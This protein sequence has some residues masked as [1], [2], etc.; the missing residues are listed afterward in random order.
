MKTVHFLLPRNIYC[1][2][3]ISILPISL[4]E[5]RKKKQDP[6]ILG[7]SIAYFPFTGN[8]LDAS[9]NGNHGNILGAVLTS[10]RN[11]E[12]NS[13]YQFD[14]I[15]A[16][17]E[18][19]NRILL[20]PEYTIAAW[21]SPDEIYSDVPSSNVAR[22]VVSLGGPGADQVLTLGTTTQG[23]VWSFFSYTGSPVIFP[24]PTVYTNKGVGARRW[25]H[26][27]AVRKKNELQLYVDGVLES[28][29]TIPEQPPLY[30]SPYN[31]FIGMRSQ[32]FPFQQFKGKIDDVAFFKTALAEEDVAI[33]CRQMGALQ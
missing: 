4:T 18:I 33:L 19:P 8:A 28:R 26:L 11:G 15:T 25:A 24:V 5:C 29:M 6:D 20:N 7:T 22:T 21:A 13:A 10:G 23:S 14:G 16:R 9:K 3:L 32:D 17:I 27:V 31:V 1:F 12:P 30:N 2:L